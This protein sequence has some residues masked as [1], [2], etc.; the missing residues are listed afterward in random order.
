MD[1]Q[2][3]KQ[4][5]LYLLL[6]FACLAQS[7]YKSSIEIEKNLEK[8]TIPWKYQLAATDYS[9]IGNYAK[10]L[11]T[12]E[13][14]RF[15][16]RPSTRED[17]LFLQSARMLNAKEYIL[18]QAK[19]APMLII[20]EAHHMPQHRAFTA[21]LLKELYANGY[22][23][24]GLEALADDSINIRKYPQLKSGFYTQ[25]PEFGNLIKHALDLGFTLFGYEAGEG[26]N[27]K[28]REIEQ[29]QNIKKFIEAH[30]EGKVV[31]HCGYAH[32]YENEYPAWEKAMAGRIKEY[33]DIDPFT[34][35]QTLFLE[36][37]DASKNHLFL[38]SFKGTEPQV[39]LDHNG[40]VFK[41]Y[42]SQ[43]DVVVIHPATRTIK[44]RPHWLYPEK[45]EYYL[46]REISSGLI[47][48]Y[49]KGETEGV[50]ADII[51]VFQ[52]STPLLLKPGPYIL[53]HGTQ[54]IQ[55]INIER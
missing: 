10:L 32:A 49:R 23:Y 1:K 51:E 18:S 50:P 42:T 11:E 40:K 27:G 21:S 31:I 7:P 9:F 47:F 55:E 44:G 29:A 24:F 46:S 20:N 3:M 8:D 34:V 17:S 48:A 14:E 2:M 25:E 45:K 35:E 15:G 26:K 33:L 38:K 6:P 19:D 12:M 41:G 37:A 22:R 16:K 54:A 5:I 52:P 43:T 13:Q 53:Y 30:P 39:L 4:I 36:R 28:E